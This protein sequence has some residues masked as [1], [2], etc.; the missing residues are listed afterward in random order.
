MIALV[1]DWLRELKLDVLPGWD[2]IGSAANVAIVPRLEVLVIQ[3]NRARC[4]DLNPVAVHGYVGHING[5]SLR[6][7]NDST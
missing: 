6:S 7:G 2:G 4:P 1:L 5:E 3:L